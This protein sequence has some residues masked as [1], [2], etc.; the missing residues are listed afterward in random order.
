MQSK[1]TRSPLGR[2]ALL[3]LAVIGVF[4]GAM[5]GAHPA[6]AHAALLV[7]SPA[8]G[9]HVHRAPTR[10][11]L[12]FS[13]SVTVPTDGIRVLG[14]G[15]TRVDRGSA[16]VQGGQV[17]IA[18]R[19]GLGDGGYVVTYR[20]ISADS[21]PIEGGFA[22]AVGTGALPS[23]RSSGGG[24]DLP[25][26]VAGA[27]LRVVEYAAGALL[28]GGLLFLVAV[29]PPAAERYT[30]LLA[31]AGFVT[32]LA[33]FGELVVQAARVSGRGLLALFTG[34]AAEAAAQRFGWST[35]FVVA[36]A[37]GGAALLLMAR[38][39]RPVLRP[40]ALAAAALVPTGWALAG[41]P[42]TGAG[43][44]WASLADLT[45]ACAACAWS[46]GVVL[47]LLT[48]HHLRRTDDPHLAASVVKRFSAVATA[49]IVAVTAAGLVLA[50]R[51]VSWHDLLDTTYG[52]LLSAKVAAVLALAALGAYNHFRLVP[53]VGSTGDHPAA[54]R[55]LG[56]TLR[57]EAAAFFVVLA[58]TA[59]LVD[60]SPPA[61]ARSRQPSR[62]DVM[63]GTLI[64]DLDASPPQ[65]GAAQLDLRIRTH[66]GNP[67]S[68]PADQLTVRLDLPAQH[69]GPITRPV[70]RIGPGHYRADGTAMTVPGDWRVTITARFSRFD[71]S[72]GSALIGID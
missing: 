45:H 50:W 37:L 7:S 63:V 62:Q 35:G 27:L 31:R 18:L 57:V 53:Q 68:L 6:A 16:D 12:R 58:L 15:G 38:A 26:Q 72:T 36:G 65:A 5:W 47:L 13:E 41:H 3:S 46:G 59:V 14:P 69:I 56:T 11:R 4:L 28:V 8:D 22:F 43:A 17:D 60:T 29:R 55:R 21:H 20:V 54:W 66:A 44:G 48:W 51:E 25:W 1:R 40:F 70:Q 2:L 71:A 49:S 10:I 64:V 32:A 9:S 39:G 34:S 33:A 30:R 23:G 19:P 61:A 67:L 24:H 42:T 52:K